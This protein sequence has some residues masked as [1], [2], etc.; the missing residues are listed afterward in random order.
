[1]TTNYRKN[2]LLR[3]SIKEQ[4]KAIIA[5]ILYAVVAPFVVHR[6]FSCSFNCRSLRCLEL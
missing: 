1:M 6:I 2:T 3:P 5:G 4:E